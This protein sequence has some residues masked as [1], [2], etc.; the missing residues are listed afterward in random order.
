MKDKSG[1]ACWVLL[2]AVAL[3]SAGCGGM[4][5]TYQASPASLLLIQNEA[6]PATKAVPASAPQPVVL[7]TVD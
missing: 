2:A 5:G 3:F 4:S 7:L 6:K 1:K